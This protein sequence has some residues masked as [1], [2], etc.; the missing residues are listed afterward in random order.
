MSLRLTA[1]TLITVMLSACEKPAEQ[2]IEVDSAA[3]E[4]G[5]EIDVAALNAA[6]PE[7]PAAFR[8]RVYRLSRHAADALTNRVQNP[9]YHVRHESS[10]GGSS[11]GPI[12]PFAAPTPAPDEPYVPVQ[13]IS[14]GETRSLEDYFEG[15]YVDFPKGTSVRYDAASEQL[16]I[17]HNL[18]AFR[19]IELI[20]DS[21]RAHA[22]LNLVVRV[23]VYEF[24]APLMLELGESAATHSD[25]TPEWDAVQRL[26]NDGDARHVSSLSTTTRS[27]QRSKVTAGKS[28]AFTGDYYW[29]ETREKFL[30]IEGEHFIGSQIEYDPVVGTDHATVDLNIAF[31]HHTSPP[32]E[33]FAEL[34]PPDSD[35]PVQLPVPIFYRH[36]TTTQITTLSGH[37]NLIGMWRPSVPPGSDQLAD[38]AQVAFLKATVQSTNPIERIR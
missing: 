35:N 2:T 25:H 37:Q 1:V 29:D 23:E 30:P 6:E 12:D 14:V 27:G 24:P 17:T 34:T 7:D 22:E 28:L 5:A 4:P 3:D 26:V 9:S 21:M 38:H 31:E 13:P 36:A 11:A 32:G 33:G 18:A 16:E 19:R 8:T 15:S 20:F 10:A